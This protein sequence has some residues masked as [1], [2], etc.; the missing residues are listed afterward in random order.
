M[1]IRKQSGNPVNYDLCR[2]TVTVYHKE[3][4]GYTRKVYRRAFL[5]FEKSQTVGKTGQEEKTGFL[6]VIPG[7]VQTVFAGDKIME[8]EGPVITSPQEW[9]EFIPDNV[10]G[11]VKAS[12]AETYSW[13]GK[14]IHTEA[15][16]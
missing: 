5:H 13:D 7:D 16:G 3:G 9:R 4:S 6:L 12:S 14:I 15:R 1:V 11:L 8:G 2:Q 10:P